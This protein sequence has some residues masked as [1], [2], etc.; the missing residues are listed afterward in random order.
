MPAAGGANG[1]NVIGAKPG[2]GQ[3]VARGCQLS[4]PYHERVVLYPARSG[5]DLRQLLL[6]QSD[7]L[8]S[9][10]N[11]MLREL[12]VPWSRASK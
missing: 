8:A 3:H 4:F 7:D 5:I 10:I 1:V 11:T 9:L 6:C 12:E 2:F